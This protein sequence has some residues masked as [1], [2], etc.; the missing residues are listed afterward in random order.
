MKTRGPAWEAFSV[1]IRV[2]DAAPFTGLCVCC[3]C[4]FSYHWKEMDAGHFI[5]WKAGNATGYEEKN[6][7]AQCKRCNGF[8]AGEQWRYSI[9]LVKKYG[10]DT[11]EKLLIQSKK[12]RKLAAFELKALAKHWREQAEKIRAE[13]KI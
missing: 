5:P 12:V 6:V 4:G 9:F 3:T 8:G 7:H 10:K 1:Y 11:P 2:R 13:K